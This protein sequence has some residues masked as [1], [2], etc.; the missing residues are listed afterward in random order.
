VTTCITP[1]RWLAVQAS[2]QQAGARFENLL[3]SVREPEAPAVGAWSVAETAAHVTGIALVYTTMLPAVAQP[4]AIPGV[5]QAIR[6][7]PLHEVGAVNELALRQ[8]TSRDPRV[9]GEKIHEAIGQ[10]LAM[11]ADL[12]PLRRVGWLGDAQLPIASWYA[13]LLN[14]LH[15][16][17]RDIAATAGTRWDVPQRDAAMSF[18]MFL[19]TLLRGDTGT[20]LAYEPMSPDRIAIRFKSQY[21]T[22]VVLAV[23]DGRIVV[24]PPQGTVDATLHFRPAALMQILF[25]RLGKTRAALTGQVVVVGR[26]PWALPAFLRAVRF[27]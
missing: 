19:V 22:P 26:R 1:E 17:G 27:P 15:L 23:E 12:D 18:E 24:D 8:L 25:N 9:I 16:H 11:S 14:E 20:L 3:S 4:S 5:D 2:L 6:R 7:A 21:T 13:H 10:L